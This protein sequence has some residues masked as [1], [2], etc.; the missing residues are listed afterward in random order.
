[1]FDKLFKIGY[2]EMAGF[3]LVTPETAD[4]VAKPVLTQLKDNFGMLPN[5]FG[6]L[7]I[8]G[9]S[10]TSFLAL[11]ETLNPQVHF[12]V[13]EQELLALAVANY[14]GCHYC[15]SAHTF[16]AKRKAGLTTEECVAAQSGESSDNR[17]KMLMTLAVNIVKNRGQLDDLLLEEARSLGFSEA[18]IVQISLLTAMN[19]FTNWLN[20]IVNPQIDFPEVELVTVE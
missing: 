17:E 10:L 3:T 8:D 12:S 2:S 9:A 18:D 20:N 11:Q 7:G 6:A 4:E 19:S 1:M 5:F 15:V 14:N 13:R 16:M